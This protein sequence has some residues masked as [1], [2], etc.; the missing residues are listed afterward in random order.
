MLQGVGVSAAPHRAGAREGA[1]H[2]T[3]ANAAAEQQARAR[4]RR[5][6]GQRGHR[7]SELRRCPLAS[8]PAPRRRPPRP[9]ERPAQPSPRPSRRPAGERMPHTARVDG[10]ARA[11]CCWPSARATPGCSAHQACSSARPTIQTK[12]G[13]PRPAFRARGPP[14]PGLGS[15]PR[16]GHQ[17]ATRTA[18][19]VV[20]SPAGCRPGALPWHCL[21]R[22]RCASHQTCA[23][24]ARRGPPC[25]LRAAPAPGSRQR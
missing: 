12:V 5:E 17:P 21:S 20:K 11:G 14:A 10:A 22:S 25:A 23:A 19:T 13:R 9:A 18:T 2:A 15:P 6:R 24:G 1:C 3:G 7:P 4:A 16:C 8:A